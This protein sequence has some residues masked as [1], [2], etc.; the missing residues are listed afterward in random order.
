MLPIEPHFMVRQIS[1]IMD[2]YG[3]LMQSDNNF[4]YIYWKQIAYSYPA[5]KAIALQR[6]HSLSFF[7]KFRGECWHYFN[8]S[9]KEKAISS[10]FF[11]HTNI[12]D[13]FADQF[14]QSPKKV[15]CW[16]LKRAIHL[17]KDRDEN[18][19]VNY[20]VFYTVVRI[21]KDSLPYLYLTLSPP[22]LT[23]QIS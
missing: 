19:D 18:N 5:E 15:I 22:S 21:K 7:K 13:L 2:I 12:S 8:Y 4:F 20:Q 10:N 9:K 16:G 1:C 6:H 11:P 17:E 23:E 14:F 3:L